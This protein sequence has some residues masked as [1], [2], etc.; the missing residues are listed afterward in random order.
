MLYPIYKFNIWQEFTKLGKT[1]YMIIKNL[2]VVNNIII[3][4]IYV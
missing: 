4:C 3:E 1:V 2:V